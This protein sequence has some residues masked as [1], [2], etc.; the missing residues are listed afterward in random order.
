[1][2]KLKLE[3]FNFCW[4]LMTYLSL[5]LNGWESRTEN[6]L[7]SRRLSIYLSL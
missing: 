7:N 6:F 4:G 1:M 3:D 2:P 5:H